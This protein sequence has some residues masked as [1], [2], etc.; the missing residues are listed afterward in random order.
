MPSANRMSTPVAI[1][2]DVIEARYATIGDYTVGFETH[3]QDVDPAP[4][5][6]G[7]PDVEQNMSAAGVVQ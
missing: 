6:A 5:F 4:L 1:D 3:K 7:L 2:E